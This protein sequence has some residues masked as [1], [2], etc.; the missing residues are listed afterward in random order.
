MIIDSSV[1]IPSSE[2]TSSLESDIYFDINQFAL[3]AMTE[4]NNQMI[5][6]ME[7]G[8]AVISESKK[9]KKKFNF[10]GILDAIVNFFCSII[11]KIVG[12][13]LAL[14]VSIGA[15]G[16]TFELE[17]RAFAN[18][19]KSYNGLFTID[20][21]YNFTHLDANDVFNTELKD[22]F[23]VAKMKYEQLF[24]TLIDKSSNAA[25][26][27][28][29]I[30]TGELNLNIDEARA[31]FRRWILSS[32]SE[33]AM[34]NEI[35]NNEC[36]KYFRGGED[37]N[38][39]TKQLSGL[40]VY[41]NFYVPY[42]DNSKLKRQCEKDK[43]ML[44]KASKDASTEIN[45]FYCITNKFNEEDAEQIDQAVMDTKR[46]ICTLFDEECKDIIIFYSNKLQAYK[47]Q[48]IQYKRV[49]TRVM[50]QVA[51]NSVGG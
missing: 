10:S 7:S 50:Q 39:G 35:Y 3:T 12:K 45:N 48:K 27:M 20:N 6:D 34:S 46:K 32:D 25:V 41:N 9:D 13:F 4:A 30:S 18:K 8:F 31:K 19:I 44:E 23:T 21:M 37:V 49:L 42:V 40:D 14:L 16:K 51:M 33:E 47:D 2:P 36:Y 22:H 5:M 28:Q 15:A 38:P 24:K 26:F 1:L 17:V 11:K 43:K 29:Q